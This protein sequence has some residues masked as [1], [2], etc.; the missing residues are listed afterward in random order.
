MQF[1]WDP[2]K[3]EINMRKHGVSFDVASSV[4][5]DPLAVTITD[6]DH[7][8]ALEMRFI[9][10]GLALT[11][12]LLVVAHTENWDTIRIISARPANS[13]ERQDYET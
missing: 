7:S 5:G 9:T 12:Q 6:P 2:A 10:V 3:A 1:A 13:H 8:T 4:F 11:M